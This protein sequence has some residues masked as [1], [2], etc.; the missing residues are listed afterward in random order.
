MFTGIIDDI[1]TVERVEESPAGLSLSVRCRY[2]DLTPGES[3]ALNG[4]CLT[5]RECGEG[6]FAVAA[7]QTT[8]ERTTIGGWTAGTR[9][10]LERAL[11]LADRLSGHLV[12]GH[13]DGV[14][15]V[16]ALIRDRSSLVVEIAV[17]PE[18][19][20]YLVP[21]GSVAVD[22]V[23]LTVHDI[24]R[25]GVARI[26]LVEYTERHTTLG[27]LRPTGRVHLEADVIGKYVRQLL[28]AAG[29]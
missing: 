5:I 13:V 15:E 8:L 11:R 7:A 22:G 25:S 21:R 10:N 6:W 4:A 12:Q 16:R 20:P 23:S 26:A 29:T 17:P 2:R 24:P 28:G 9:V 19:A 14:G 18:V 27:D 3:V 1:G